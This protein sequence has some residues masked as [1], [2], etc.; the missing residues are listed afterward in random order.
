ML[1]LKNFV[2]LV[3]LICLS[4]CKESP[5]TG[6]RLP[7]PARTPRILRLISLSD[8]QKKVFESGEEQYFVP[9]SCA[10]YFE[11]DCCAGELYFN[12][13]FSYYWHHWCVGTE[14]YSYGSYSLS[15]DTLVLHHSGLS[16]RVLYNE[17]REENDSIHPEYFYKNSIDLAADIK[18]L[19]TQCSNALILKQVA[20]NTFVAETKSDYQKRISEMKQAGFIRKLDSLRAVSK[21]LDLKR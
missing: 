8:F 20:G 9:G 17:A 21:L 5:S 1:N 12:S 19:A 16:S 2:G 15:G 13:D 18:F 4:S 6:N 14:E 3:I 10:F 7:E 11:C